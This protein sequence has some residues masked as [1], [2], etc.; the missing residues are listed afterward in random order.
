MVSWVF[1]SCTLSLSS[2]LSSCLHSISIASVS[3]AR[4]YPVFLSLDCPGADEVFGWMYDYERSPSQDP[5][6][7]SVHHADI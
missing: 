2:F 3:K 7:T 4:D 6:V 5:F 1:T